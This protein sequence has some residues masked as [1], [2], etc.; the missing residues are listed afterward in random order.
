MNIICLDLESIL[1]PEIWEEVAEE[2]N[3]KELELTTRDIE[4]YDELMAHRYQV[5]KENDIDIEYI[6]EVIQNIHPLEGAPEFV[7][8]A[9]Q[10]AQV[11][12]LTDSFYEFINPIMKEFNKPM[13]FART[14]HWN[15]KGYLNGYTP[16]KNIDIK[17]TAIKTFNKI[18]L[19][20]IAVGD[21]FNDLTMLRQANKGYLYKP[22]QDVKQN[23]KDIEKKQNYEEL[24]QAIK[25]EL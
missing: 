16:P 14:L 5:L 11:A 23:V 19:N 1:I 24:K 9:R 25:K 15:E 18:N 12:I 8:W 17:L 13:V 4:D 21:S 6:K 22:S 10:K 20:T 2:T 7:K 3:I